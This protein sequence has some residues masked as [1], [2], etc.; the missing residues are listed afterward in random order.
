MLCTPREQN[1]LNHLFLYTPIKMH[2]ISFPVRPSTH[3]L[4]P[5]HSFIPSSTHHYLS[6][7]VQPSTH[8]GG[9]HGG[10]VR[11]QTGCRGGGQQRG[12]ALEVQH[13]HSFHSHAFI[14]KICTAFDRCTWHRVLRHVTLHHTAVH[15]AAFHSV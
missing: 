4:T 5:S 14:C 6:E 7:G 9:L 2:L 10:Q 11:G 8:Q 1:H 13:G 3:P 15:V 12:R